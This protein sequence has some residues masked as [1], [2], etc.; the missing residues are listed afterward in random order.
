MSTYIVR[1]DVREGP[2]EPAGR[3]YLASA[4]IYGPGGVENFGLPTSVSNIKSIDAGGTPALSPH[5]ALE[6]ALE[7]LIDRI[8][9]GN[10]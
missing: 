2:R 3:I 7:V 4:E 8:R 10:K 5:E 9:Y 6:Q 1:V